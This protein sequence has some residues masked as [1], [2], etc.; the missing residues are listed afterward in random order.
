MKWHFNF[1][2]R[3]KRIL[4]EFGSLAAYLVNIFAL[5]NLI[6]CNLRFHR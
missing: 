5:T 6:L 2:V 4:Y 3:N 1:I